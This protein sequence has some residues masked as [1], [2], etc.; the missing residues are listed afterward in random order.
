M[1][2]R[3]LVVSAAV[4][5]GITC[6]AGADLAKADLSFETL[7]WPIDAKSWYQPFYVSSEDSFQHIGLVLTP[8]DTTSGFKAPAWDFDT[9]DGNPNDFSSDGTN[10]TRWMDWTIA[11]GDPTQDL[12]WRSHFA[13]NR[14]E[15]NFVL[16]LFAFDDSLHWDVATA[17]WSGSSWDFGPHTAGVTWEEFKDLGGVAAVVPVPSAA[18]LGL[19]GLGLVSAI[20]RR[21]R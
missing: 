21:V 8:F 2:T 13:G 19:T 17:L 15:Q 4:L 12:L 18:L 11:S 3:R 6:G 5:W 14:R 1:S 20:R 16:T 7:G 9:L 10:D